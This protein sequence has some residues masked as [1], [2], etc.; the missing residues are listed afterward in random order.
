MST[1]ESSVSHL[2]SLS[3]D[4]DGEIDN[5]RGH[6]QKR[7][8]TDFCDKTVSESTLSRLGSC[9]PHITAVSESHQTP[10]FSAHEAQKLIQK[11]LNHPF[12]LNSKKQVAFHS[13]LSSLRQSLN[14]SIMANRFS[15]AT[16]PEEALEDLPMPSIALMQWML[17]CKT[18][19]G[20]DR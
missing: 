10:P 6:P 2:I 20:T 5:S 15:R 4:K 19:P 1:L 13:A 3:T 11:E 9:S 18:P 17:Q 14:T 12:S 16:I 8:R 7:S